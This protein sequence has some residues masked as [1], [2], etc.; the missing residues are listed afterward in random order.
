MAKTT[1]VKKAQA[2]FE[3]V[4]VLDSDGQPKRTPVMKRVWDERAEEYVQKQKTTKTGKPVFMTVT[5]QDRTKPLPPY[6][7][8]AC[9]LP[10]EVGTP[11]KHITPKSGPYGGRKRT[12]HE[13]CPSWNV[14]DYSNSLSAQLARIAHDFWE[15]VDGAESTDDVQSALDDAGSEVTS[16]AEQKKEAAQNIEDG[17]GWETEKSTEL[18]EIAE[19]LEQWAG[20][21]PSADI[22]EIENCEQCDDGKVDCDACGGGGRVEDVEGEAVDCPDCEGSGQQDC[23]DCDG[24]GEDLEGWREA[25]RSDVTVVDESP[26]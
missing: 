18:A 13:S 23:E 4:P 8:D 19:S 24:T 21:I 22:P 12:R 26:V 17:F 25:V 2:R 14:W 3:T 1:H 9:H 6:E 20:E 15:Q 5:V 10:I 16:I 7:C 11:Y